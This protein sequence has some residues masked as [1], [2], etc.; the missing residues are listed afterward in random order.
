MG[1]EQTVCCGLADALKH[2]LQ[3][4][5]NLLPAICCFTSLLS[6]PSK[7]FWFYLICKS[8]LTIISIYL[9]FFLNMSKKKNFL[10]KE[11]TI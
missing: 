8:N 2:E 1:E 7:S 3:G 10:T 6:C 11:N 4:R 9:S 5:A